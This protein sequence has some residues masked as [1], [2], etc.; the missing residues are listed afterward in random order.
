VIVR[1]DAQALIALSSDRWGALLPHVRRAL[2]AL[3]AAAVTPGI[4]RLRSSPP[5]A[6]ASGRMRR[7]LATLLADDERVWDSLLAALDPLPD[8]LAWMTDEP[9]PDDAGPDDASRSAGSSEAITSE[10]DTQERARLRAR[11]RETQQE[12][13]V[14][15]R[16]A[17]GAEA[18]AEQAL[19]RAEAAERGRADADARVDDL[20][21]RLAAQADETRRA[22]EREARRHAGDLAALRVDLTAARQRVHE[23]ERALEEERVRGRRLERER[24]RQSDAPERPDVSGLKVGRP[25]RLPAGVAPDTSEAAELLLAPGRQVL[26]DGYNVTLRHREGLGLEQQRAWLVRALATYVARV[27]IRPIVVFD[28][29]R[30]GGGSRSMPRAPGVQVRFT[31]AGIIADDEIVF[32]VEATGDPVVVVTDDQGLRARVAALGADIIGTV[33]LVGVIGA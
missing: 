2:H 10:A 1:R 12:R 32:A 7:D 33:N 28:G 4:V 21:V 20:E 27:P 6:L 14:V 19:R 5:S 11:L 24:A 23:L 29:D 17:D 18:R 15:K 9:A 30:S 13:D 8:D 22:V 25:T 31:V 3:P 26:V 16:R